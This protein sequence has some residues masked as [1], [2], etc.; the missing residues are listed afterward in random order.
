MIIND[1]RYDKD[2]PNIFKNKKNFI[3]F[4]KFSNDDIINFVKANNNQYKNIKI[5]KGNYVDDL[6][7]TKFTNKKGF[8]SY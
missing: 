1:L 6:I 4:E 2:N 5:K 8:N 7:T 3:S